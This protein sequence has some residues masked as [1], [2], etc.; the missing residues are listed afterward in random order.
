[1][2]EIC[3][4][5][6]LRRAGGAGKQQGV[7]SMPFWISPAIEFMAVKNGLGAACPDDVLIRRLIDQS[8]VA[9]LCRMAG[10]SGI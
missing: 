6:A 8:I 10:R 3:L 9:G 2:K 4:A 5:Q 7:R 1:M